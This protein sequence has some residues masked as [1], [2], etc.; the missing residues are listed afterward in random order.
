MRLY[1][2]N[3]DIFDLKADVL[4]C[5]ANV[6]LMLTG[7]VGADLLKHFPDPNYQ[8]ELRSLLCKTTGRKYA[9]PGSVFSLKPAGAPYKAVLHA[10][11]SDPMYHSSKELISN[12]IK[13]CLCEAKKLSA[14][15]I[16][17][18]ALATGFGDLTISDF[19]EAAS[20]ALKEM[21]KSPF[22]KIYFSIIDKDDFEEFQKEFNLTCFLTTEYE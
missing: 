7:G 11:A 16:A 3:S 17:F 14:T 15:S 9:E 4:V 12:L 22:D 6:S 20:T 21:S 5:S 18:P 10:I 2:H 19:A 1:L 8:E 13:N